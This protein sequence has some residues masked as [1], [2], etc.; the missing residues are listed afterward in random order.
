[1][2]DELRT[3]KDIPA[4]GAGVRVDVA[5]VIGDVFQYSGPLRLDTAREEIP[6]WDSLRHVALVVAVEGTFDI[7]LSMDEM[8]EI[9]SIGDLQRVLER[10]GK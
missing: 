9:L 10:H 8:Q 2:Q 6:R 4:N 5:D 7:S 1:M 3:S